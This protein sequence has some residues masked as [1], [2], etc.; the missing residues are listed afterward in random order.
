MGIKPG[1]TRDHFLGSRAFRIRALSVPGRQDSEDVRRECRPR[2]VTSG[3][4]NFSISPSLQTDT[5]KTRT[6][7]VVGVAKVDCPL[8]SLAMLTTVHDAFVPG[9]GGNAGG[10]SG[11]PAAEAYV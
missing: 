11:A 5:L 10:T 4:Q 7:K 9:I 2:A 1:V 6:C 8:L 3:T